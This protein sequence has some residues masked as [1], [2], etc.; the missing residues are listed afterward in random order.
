MNLDSMQEIVAASLRAG[1]R[2]W[3]IIREMAREAR[4]K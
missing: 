2:F 4:E 3:E 1:K